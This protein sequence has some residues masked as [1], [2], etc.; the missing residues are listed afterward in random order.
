MRATFVVSIVSYVILELLLLL[1][2]VLLLL[3]LRMPLED[4]ELLHLSPIWRR[5]DS[6]SP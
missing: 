2:L 6:L 4:F 1:L 5:P 3:L